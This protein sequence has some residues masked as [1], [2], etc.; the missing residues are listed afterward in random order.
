MQTSTTFANPSTGRLG[1]SYGPWA[2]ITGATEGIG[3]ACADHLAGE[4]FGLV[5]VARR[6]GALETTARLLA[7]RY[8]IETRIVPLDLGRE[9]AAD[10][11]DDAT[12]DLD[13]G[14]LI[15]AAGFGTSGD[16]LDGDVE[17]ETDMLRVNCEAVL[18]LTHH[19]GRRFARRGGGGVVLMSSLVAFQGVPRAAH[20]AATKAWVQTLAEALALEWK[21][22]GVDVVA[23]APGPV[24]TPFADR[25]NM[26]M[27]MAVDASTVARQ[28]LNALGRRVT[29]RPGFLSK[30][31]ETLLTLPR[32]ARTRIMQQVM[33]GMTKHQSHEPK[34]IETREPA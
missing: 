31:L 27:D 20:Y 32:F 5:L 1:R 34:P 17:T 30:F 7:T 23:S 12:T 33:L 18:K 29:V 13:V 2:V 16:F 25:A 22:L 28:T 4:G 21:P 6:Q 15:A 8:G 10:A 14:L 26:R 24:R 11:L 3:R 19:F 9:G